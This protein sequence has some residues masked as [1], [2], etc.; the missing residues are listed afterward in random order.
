M[1]KKAGG[2]PKRHLVEA[3][4][5][6]FFANEVEDE[7]LRDLK[8]TRIELSNDRTH[9]KLYYLPPEGFADF[10]ADA[11][12]DLIPRLRARAAEVLFHTP[13]LSVNLDRGAGNK[14]RVEEILEEL[15]GDASS[16][17]EASPEPDDEKPATP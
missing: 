10:A 12:A 9:V 7:R 16:P 5:Q 8:V 2:D 17:E 6:A 1:G 13:E 3:E 11:M 15:R 14:R 4:L